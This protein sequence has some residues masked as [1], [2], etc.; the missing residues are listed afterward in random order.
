MTEEKFLTAKVIK[1]QLK[2]AKD[3]LTW[4]T[5]YSLTVKANSNATIIAS[6]I[7]ETNDEIKFLENKFNEL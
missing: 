6:L 4:L 2:S 5:H 7:N 1:S 3:R